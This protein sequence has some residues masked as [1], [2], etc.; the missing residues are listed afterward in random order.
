LASLLFRDAGVHRYTAEAG[1]K[2][3]GALQRSFALFKTGAMIPEVVFTDRI[4]LESV[5]TAGTFFPLECLAEL[6]HASP[7][8]PDAGRDA[9]AGRSS[10][11]SA[12]GSESLVAEDGGAPSGTCTT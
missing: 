9:E 10:V 11:C 6:H 3:L 8:T 12:R 7:H 2:F 1:G 4:A 5:P